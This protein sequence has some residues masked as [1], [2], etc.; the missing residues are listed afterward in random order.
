MGILYLFFS[1]MSRKFTGY[2]HERPLSSKKGVKYFRFLIKVGYILICRLKDS[3]Y[4]QSRPIDFWTG[5]WINKLFWETGVAVFLFTTWVYL[6]LFYII[7]LITG[8]SW[9]VIHLIIQLMFHMSFIYLPNYLASMLK[10]I[11][12]YCRG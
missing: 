2:I 3:K 6:F 10:I 12:A 8:N 11:L 4:L 9:V 5:H 7:N 1:K